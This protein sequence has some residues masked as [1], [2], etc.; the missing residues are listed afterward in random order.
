MNIKEKNELKKLT[1]MDV[2]YRRELRRQVTL[3]IKKW[4]NSG[5]TREELAEAMNVTVQ[6]IERWEW[7]YAQST[8]VFNMAYWNMEKMTQLFQKEGYY[9]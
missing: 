3:H 4:L 7:G 6:T 9:E 8:G 1:D 2:E 5:R